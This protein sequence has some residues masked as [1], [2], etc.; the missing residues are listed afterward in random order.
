MRAYRIQYDITAEFKQVTLLFYKNRLEPSF[1]NMPVCV[2]HSVVRLGV[3]AVQVAHAGRKV[4]FRCFDEE[5]IVIT[6]QAVG[7]T[8]PVEALYRL[9]EDGEKEMAVVVIFE[10]ISPGVAAR[11]N[12]IDGTGKFYA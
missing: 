9:A 5:V 2:V 6:H 3:D 11:G 12:V 10:D 7:V 4:P 8:E 1:E